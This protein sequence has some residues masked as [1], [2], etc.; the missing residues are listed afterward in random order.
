M[1]IEH[2]VCKSSCFQGTERSLR[3]LVFSCVLVA[4]FRILFEVGLC[5]GIQLRLLVNTGECCGDS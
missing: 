3:L 4:T 2:T 5:S 1:N